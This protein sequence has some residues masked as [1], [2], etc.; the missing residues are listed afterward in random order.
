MPEIRYAIT[1]DESGAVTSMR[2]MAG[3]AQSAGR[4][5]ATAFGPLQRSLG[6]VKTLVAGLGLT[7]G[8]LGIAQVVRGGIGALA[9]FEKEMANVSTLMNTAT[10]EG[11]RQFER[12][13]QQILELPPAL[14]SSAELARGLYQ[15]LS[16]GQ[17]PASAVKFVGDAAVFAKAALTD[18]FTAVDVL[19]TILNAY[20]LTAEKTASVSSTLFKTIELGKTTGPELA[21][22]LGRVIPVAASM[23]IRLEELSAALA[24]LTIG[25]IST[26]ESVTAL[27]QSLLGILQPTKQAEEEAKKLGIDFG[28]MRKRISTDGL[29]QVMGELAEKTK[30][31]SELTAQLFGNVRALIGVLALTGP[32]AGKYR[33]TLA[34]IEEASQAANRADVALEKQLRT[35]SAQWEEFWTILDRNVQSLIGSKGITTA[36]T[37]VN[38]LL[39]IVIGGLAKAIGVVVSLTSAIW[40]LIAAFAAFKILPV[41]QLGV[42]KLVGS[43]ALLTTGLTTAGAAI[44]PVALALGGLAAVFGT[45]LL[46]DRALTKLKTLDQELANAEDELQRAQRAGGTM[47]QRLAELKDHFDRAGDSARG[48]S[49]DLDLGRRALAYYN[50]QLKKLKEEMDPRTTKAFR[51][52]ADSLT[53]F[54]DAGYEYNASLQQAHETTKKMVEITQR[55]NALIEMSGYLAS[56]TGKKVSVDLNTAMEEYGNAGG[57]VHRTSEQIRKDLINL[58]V[59]VANLAAKWQSASGTIKETPAPTPAPAMTEELSKFIRESTKAAREFRQS[60]E[61]AAAEGPARI[62]LNVQRELEQMTTFVDE[63]GAVSRVRLTAEARAD[64]E[65]ALQGQVLALLKETT[66]KVREA[67]QNRYDLLLGYEQTLLQRKISLDEEE[68]RKASEVSASLQQ[69]DER[70][71]TVQRDSQLR[72][73]ELINASTVSEKVAVEQRKLDIELEYLQR[74]HDFRMQEIATTRDTEIAALRAVYGENLRNKEALRKLEEIDRRDAIR[75]AQELADYQAAIDAARQTVAIRQASIAQGEQQRVFDSLKRQAEGVFDALTVRSESV[76]RAI[77]NAFKT[78]ILTAI[79]EIVSSQVARLLMRLF[80]GVGYAPAGGAGGGGV[81]FRS[82]AASLLGAGLAF[83]G[84]GMPGGTAGFAGPVE[85]IRT[86]WGGLNALQLAPGSMVPLAQGAQGTASVAPAMGLGTSLTA[87]L[88]ALLTIAAI[89]RR[90]GIGAVGGSALTGAALGSA[91]LLGPGFGAAAGGVAGAGFGLAAAGVMRG[92]LSGLGM[93]IG[94]GALVG[95]QFGGPIGAAIGAGAGAI[96]GLIGLFRKSAVEKAREKIRA[97]YGV[98]VRDKGILRQVV[99]IAKQSFGGSL[100]TAIRGAQ[101]RELIVLYAL[102]TGQRGNFPA[103][104]QP[105]IVAQSAGVLYPMPAGL[106]QPAG[107]SPL[108]SGLVQPGGAGPAGEPGEIGAIG[109][110]LMNRVIS[111]VKQEISTAVRVE[112]PLTLDGQV[113]ERKTLE[114]MLKNGRAVSAAIVSGAKANAGRRELAALQLSPGALTS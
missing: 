16:A 29:L 47:G 10:A 22:A 15:A 96:A 25:G 73:L 5:S 79:K 14:G 12:M 94:G 13:T 103:K 37:A 44:P 35:S 85:A 76:A 17:A 99:E 24:T 111:Q 53:Q 93:A 59:D 52:G 6:S 50:E 41:V 45:G 18:T 113:I 89:Q 81:G 61:E 104:M 75:K 82:V 28:D 7:F 4:Q 91:G 2:R 43:I 30:G 66:A 33:E 106:T 58:G 112:V 70:A 88:G 39:P 69:L 102:S 78:A 64:M 67:D 74:M 54:S 71:L 108:P 46:I 55:V 20:G 57:P 9:G 77:A 49:D 26:D 23:N 84:A 8:A 83:G 42:T 32:Q 36:L 34:Q 31:N 11:Q 98:E 40:P 92:G 72:N 56:E 1:V 51:E 107:I 80:S 87:G 19:T 110:G 27:R 86:T 63:K 100:D 60:V 114:V 48:F 95:L 90:S 62:L 101:I 97:I 38:K 105:L 3:E 21:G 65:K 68:L 109:K